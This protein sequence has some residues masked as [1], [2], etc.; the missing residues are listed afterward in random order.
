MK[1][2]PCLKGSPNHPQK[3]SHSLTHHTFHFNFITFKYLTSN[4]NIK[5]QTLLQLKNQSH[6]YQYFL[7]STENAIL[8]KHKI[9]GHTIK[10]H[11]G[12]YNKSRLSFTE[13]F[14]TF[15]LCT[16]TPVR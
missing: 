2:H 4:H 8:L 1:Q 3:I 7:H 11:P 10:S 13:Q 5:T 16:K 12:V 14:A 9:L 6:Q 15:D